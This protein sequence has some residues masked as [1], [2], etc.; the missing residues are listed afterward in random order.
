LDVPAVRGAGIFSSH[1][2][3]VNASQ[4]FEK[5]SGSSV[6]VTTLTG[7]IR[8]ICRFEEVDRASM[9]SVP[10]T[11]MAEEIELCELLQFSISPQPSGGT[12]RNC[13]CTVPK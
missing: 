5:G 9:Y 4:A 13:T 1:E 10:C 8:Y 11:A 7:S 12:A 3:T 6:P 2:K